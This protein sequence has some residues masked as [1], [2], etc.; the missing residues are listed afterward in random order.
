MRKS[1]GLS[2]VQSV[3]IS[4]EHLHEIENIRRILNASVWKPNTGDV[5][6]LGVFVLAK[7]D[8]ET[9]LEQAKELWEK[10]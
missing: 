7:L 4:G 10:K 5:F 2:K 3:R 8:K 9:L 6:R 1:E